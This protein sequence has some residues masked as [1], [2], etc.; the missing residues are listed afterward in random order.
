MKHAVQWLR[1]LLFVG[2]MYLMMAVFALIFTPFA[3]V[4]RKWVF[5][6]VH[7][8]CHWV[9]WT[10]RWMVGLRS[11]VRGEVPRDEVLIA[12]KHQSFFDII[13]IVSETPRPKFIMKS[14]LK[15]APILGWYALR[16]G[17]IPVDRGRRAEAIR[18]MMAGVKSGE[19]K[20]GQLIIYPQGTRVAPG[21]EKPY[22]I[23]AG[24]LYAELGQDCVP[25]ATNVGVFWP[26]TGIYRKPGLAV[27]EFLPRIQAG[28][29]TGAFMARLEDEIETASDRLM[30]EAG[31]RAKG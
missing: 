30:D 4:S 22:K 29:E 9:R 11:E 7:A 12:S 31:F 27:V 18:Q 13:L 17:C 28:L 15:W 24:V 16:I 10:A 23:G 21:V 14:S 6:A 26:R 19:Q 20:P 1:S 2:Q 25:A 3:L 5:H 8:Y